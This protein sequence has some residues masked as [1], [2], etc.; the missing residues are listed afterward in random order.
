MID[1]AN[2]RRFEESRNEFW[3]VLNN[4]ELNGIPLLIVGNKTDLVKLSN[5][6]FDEQVQN[7][8][9]ELSTFYNL[10]KIKRRKWNFLFTSVK[11]NYNIDSVIPAIFDLLSS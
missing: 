5:D 10:N 7:L 1:V 3:N 4:D 8:K 6:N 11:T 2:Q 9:E